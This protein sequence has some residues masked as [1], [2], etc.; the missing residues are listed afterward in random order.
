M[1]VRPAECAPDQVVAE[2]EEADAGEK[3]DAQRA[4]ALAEEV[5]VDHVDLDVLDLVVPL[6]RLADG[7][8]EPVV[9]VNAVELDQ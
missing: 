3:I 2:A 1:A 9:G 8:I 6:E 4:A 7:V 5:V